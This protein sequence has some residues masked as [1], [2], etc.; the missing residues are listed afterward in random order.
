M[1]E[2]A[3]DGI[4]AHWFHGDVLT[5][6]NTKFL[7]ILLGLAG[8]A[9][10]GPV[11]SNPER[12][13]RISVTFISPERFT[14]VSRRR[15]ASERE[16]DGILRELAATMQRS[17]GEYLRDDL[18]LEIAVKDVDLAGDFE[19]WRRSHFDDVRI[20][21]DLYPPRMNI[22]YRLRD[23]RGR[24]VKQGEDR[25]SDQN[26]LFGTVLTDSDP[27][28]HDKKLFRDWLRSEFTEYRR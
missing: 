12:N 4:R 14:D 26:Y 21:R 25:L 2:Y 28:R 6:M 15:Y 17:A 1:E 10:A 8:V 27:L 19:W 9:V 3:F 5:V 7:S 16:R 11:S 23:A 13:S 22:G 18:R 20:V 24:L